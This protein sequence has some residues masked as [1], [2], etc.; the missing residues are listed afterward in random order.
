MYKGVGL[1]TSRGSG[2]NGRTQS[3]KFLAKPNYTCK[4]AGGS[5]KS[6]E[7]DRGTAAGEMRKREKETS[8]HDRKRRV[9]LKL[10]VLE[11]ELI[12]QG[13]TDAEIA[14]KLDEARQSLSFN[15]ID[16]EFE[17][18]V[19]HY[20]DGLTS[21]WRRIVLGQNI[22]NLI[23]EAQKYFMGLFNYG[24]PKLLGIS[25]ELFKFQHDSRPSFSLFL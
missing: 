8:E 13:C 19:L 10:L 18:R 2:T 14:V 24:S 23:M 6:S 12:D 16:W 17:V 11:E 5:S 21:N 3:N 25:M 9:E 15:E 22:S 1:P 20:V 7:S 4:I